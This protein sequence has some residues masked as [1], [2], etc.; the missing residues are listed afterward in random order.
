MDT[1][2]LLYEL[3]NAYTD[4]GLCGSNPAALEARRIRAG[5]NYYGCLQRGQNSADIN[6]RWLQQRLGHGPSSRERGR[7]TRST[8]TW[9]GACRER[10]W[11]PRPGIGDLEVVLGRIAR[12]SAAEPRR[13]DA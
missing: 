10:D 3:T 1:P 4:Q 7:R 5:I 8:M 6:P 13:V 12:S 2:E 9:S 11:V